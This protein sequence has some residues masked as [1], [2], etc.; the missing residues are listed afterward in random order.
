MSAHAL[1]NLLNK[2][3]KSYKMRG[4]PSILS[5]F[6]NKLNKYNNT[7]AWLLDSNYHM[8]L[9]LLKNQIFGVKNVKI[10]PYFTQRYNGR[11]YITLLNL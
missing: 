2:L 1:L 9:K 11:H 3:R 8:K 7:R 5:L 10:L 6:C 4:M